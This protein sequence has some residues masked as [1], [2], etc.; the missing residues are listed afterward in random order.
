MAKSVEEQDLANMLAYELL[1]KQI[2][3]VQLSQTTN[4]TTNSNSDYKTTFSNLADLSAERLY[5]EFCEAA[6]SP[7]CTFTEGDW[8]CI[9][10]LEHDLY[11]E[12][13][14]TAV[15]RLGF[16]EVSPKKR[17]QSVGNFLYNLKKRR[18]YEK[19]K[20]PYWRTN[21]RTIEN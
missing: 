10:F 12:N 8:Q 17:N 7:F 13:G 6:Y 21:P 5:L 18:D 4:E 19:T 11:Y 2:Q 16:C 14:I 9:A 15:C 1:K 20:K 3:N